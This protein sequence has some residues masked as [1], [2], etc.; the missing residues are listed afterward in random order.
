MT[1]VGARW[2][3]RLAALLLVVLCIRLVSLGLYP[4]MDTTEPRYAE[5]ARKML[6]SGDW[7]TP[8][9]DH[10]V[11]FWGKPPMSFWASAASMALLGVN[12]IGARLAPFIATVLTVALLWAWPRRQ[13]DAAEIPW[14]AGV[15][16]ASSLLGFVSAGAVMTDMFMVLGTTLCMVGFRR[17]MVDQ[18]PG[19]WPWLFFIGLAIG[20]LA[21]GP[22]ATVLTMLALGLWVLWNR[23]WG[24][25]WR[26]L[27][28]FRGLLVTLVVVTPWYLLAEYRTPG[29]LRYF[30]IGEHVQR[31]LVSG[32]NGDLYG[33]PHS[34]VRGTIWWY[35][36]AGYMPW[37]VVALVAAVLAARR[38][39]AMAGA[40]EPGECSYLMSWLLAGACFF[41]ASHNV[42][43]PYV[44]PGLPAF[45]LLTALLM[46]HCAVAF[47]WI[48][49][50]YWSALIVPS[51][52]VV[53]LLAAPQALEQRSQ[54]ELLRHWP[55]GEALA[56]IGPRP[57]SANFY[58]HG[59]ALWLTQPEAVRK[60]LARS[61]PASLVV[62]Q[63]VLQGLDEVALKRWTPVA[64]HAG[65]VLLRREAE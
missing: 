44:L 34:E 14:A 60:W 20:L 57:F 31:F 11:P 41:T 30:I 50:A 52:V 45:A 33:H 37:T 39:P 27:P 3:R 19:I 10:G 63:R 15:V 40:F 53:L 54:R 4:L 8:W 28:W 23:S 43:P 48:R 6:A 16:L 35:A 9:F 55:E 59:Q 62:E 58:S 12:E 13:T 5:I 24:A 22:V 64:R 65:Y 7:V 47:A 46:R 51:V 25:A 29:F 1:D 42:L 17:A 61:G 56:Y 26:R 2:S 32:W 18:K 38:G 49:H 36:L 21:K